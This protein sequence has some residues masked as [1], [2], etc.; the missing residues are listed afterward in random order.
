MPEWEGIDRRKTISLDHDVL[1]E[2]KNDLKHVVS[3]IEAH[4]KKD[5]VRFTKIDKD[6]DFQKRIT[7]A[8]LGI[9]FFVEFMFKFIK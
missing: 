9:I 8:V 4:E 3:W 5:D 6:I 7:Y 1:I 2:I